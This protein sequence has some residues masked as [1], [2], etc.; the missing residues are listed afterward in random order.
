MNQRLPYSL[1]ALSIIICLVN[2]SSIAQVSIRPGVEGGVG[3]ES[4]VYSGVPNIANLGT[5]VTSCSKKFTGGGICEFVFTK[6]YSLQTG[7]LYSDRG[8]TVSWPPFSEV[9]SIVGKLTASYSFT[10]IAI[11]LDFRLN[12]PVSLNFSPYILAGINY[13]FLQHATVNA[14]I[15]NY[16]NGT[17]IGENILFLVPM[18]PIMQIILIL[19]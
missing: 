15:M 1:N 16:S 4:I 6:M 10:Y 7:I 14:P 8:G 11:P 9:P 12:I 3:F 5:P 13:A 19:D 18:L 2:I 17:Y